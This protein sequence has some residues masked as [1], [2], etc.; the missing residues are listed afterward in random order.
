MIF[1]KHN[2]RSAKRINGLVV[3]PSFVVGKPFGSK[4]FVGSRPFV[5]NRPFVRESFEVDQ[6]QGLEVEQERQ[7]AAAQESDSSGGPS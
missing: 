7:D 3:V 4:P 1:N 2:H 5:G 6:R